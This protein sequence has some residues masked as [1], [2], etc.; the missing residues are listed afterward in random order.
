MTA[1]GDSADWGFLCHKLWIKFYEE[2]SSELQRFM[3]LWV[4]MAT[5]HSRLVVN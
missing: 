1:V 3:Y 4:V 2:F 5:Y